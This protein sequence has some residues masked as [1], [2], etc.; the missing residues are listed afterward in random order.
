MRFLPVFT[1][2]VTYSYY[3]DGRCSDFSIEP[4]SA[5]ETLL[6][7]HHCILKSLPDGIRVLM[8]VDDEGVP[9]VTY[10]QDAVCNFHL[11][12]RN[13]DFALFT[14][15]SDIVNRVAPVY[16]NARQNG[17]AS[18]GIRLES[19]QA[20]STERFVIV[21]PAPE[22]RF[23]LGGRPLVDLELA[24]FETAGPEGVEM[25]AYNG[26][27]RTITV[28]TQSASKDETFT[29]RYP[30]LPR[31]ERGVF[32]DV[33]IH[34]HGTFQPREEGHAEF[35]IAFTAKKAKWKYYL[36]T[37][38]NSTAVQNWQESFGDAGIVV[39]YRGA[40]GA[41][42]QVKI[43]EGLAGESV[44]FGIAGRVL[45][46]SNV[47]GKTGTNVHTAW[48]TWVA[49]PNSPNGFDITINGDG[50]AHVE[51]TSDAGVELVKE[52]AFQLLD[53]QNKLKF[54][55]NLDSSDEVAKELVEKYPDLH[56]IRFVSDDAISC[57]EITRKHLRLNFENNYLF[58]VL[59]NPS[60]RNLHGQDAFFAIV[61]YLTQ[62]SPKKG[63]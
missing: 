8:R 57:S 49:E 4:D 32:A 54:V 34:N 63:V 20:W 46:I 44:A 17:G 1:L 55:K 39:K 47:L 2:R 21:R 60:F 15:L 50:S 40:G 42:P 59:P 12:L 37:D 29:I 25:K 41:T 7:N 22:D 24:R 58:E 52:E 27:R 16:T 38:L 31:L 30:V 33:E 14:D 23:K 19:R 56:I 5:T 3:A 43:A 53:T 9:L 26:T 51:H 61:K 13:P 6:K 45:S 10:A 18:L 28:D 36:V 11:R 62:S 48:Q 35:E